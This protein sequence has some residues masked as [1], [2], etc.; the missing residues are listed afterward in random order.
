M[1]GFLPLH[2]IV[3]SSVNKNPLT[4]LDRFVITSFMTMRNRLTFR[5]YPCGTLFSMIFDEEK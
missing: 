5:T 4:G 1:N 2:I 3:R